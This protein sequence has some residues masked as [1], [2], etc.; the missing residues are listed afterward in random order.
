MPVSVTNTGKGNYRQSD[1]VF[2]WGLKISA[3]GDHSGGRIL[4]L[5]FFKS[6]IV[7][8]ISLNCELRDKRIIG[9]FYCKSTNSKETISQNR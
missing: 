9:L 3:A 7:R 5:K 1:Q 8:H 6:P 4:I 2:D